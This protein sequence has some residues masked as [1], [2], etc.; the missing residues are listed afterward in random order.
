MKGKRK[1]D[2]ARSD[3]VRTQK[4]LEKENKK[5]N[6]LSGDIVANTNYKD[7]TGRWMCYKKQGSDLNPDDFSNWELLEI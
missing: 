2:I 5:E 4:Y 1:S 7:F 6:N 3:P